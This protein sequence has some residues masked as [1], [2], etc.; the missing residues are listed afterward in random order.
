MWLSNI[1]FSTCI[2]TIGALIKININFNVGAILVVH[3]T[4]G[5]VDTVLVKLDKV[6]FFEFTGRDER[7]ACLVSRWF[8]TMFDWFIQHSLWHFWITSVDEWSN[9]KIV[10]VGY[11]VRKVG[12]CIWFWLK[13]Q[14]MVLWRNQLIFD[15]INIGKLDTGADMTCRFE[16]G[17]V[18]VYPSLMDRDSCQIPQVTELLDVI[19]WFLQANEESLNDHLMY[20]ENI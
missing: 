8:Q 19:F 1:S 7:I 17:T 3:L 16:K 18:I 15:A 4:T 12:T 11:G 2:T 6:A 20:T 5:L 13:C 14:L 9:E 10:L